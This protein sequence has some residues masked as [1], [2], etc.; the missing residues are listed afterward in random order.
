MASESTQERTVIF[1]YFTKSAFL[2]VEDSLEIGKLRLFLGKYKR[3]DGMQVGTYHF[4]DVDAARPLLMDLSWARVVKFIDYKGGSNG[5]GN[6]ISRVLS[7]KSQDDSVWFEVKNGPGKKSQ[8]GAVMPAGDATSDVSIPLKVD[9]ARRLA[10]ALL[11]YI[12]AHEVAQAVVAMLDGPASPAPASLATTTSSAVPFVPVISAGLEEPQ[13]AP[14]PPAQK[15]AHPGPVDGDPG[16]SPKFLLQEGIV[17]TEADGRI[18]MDLLGIVDGEPSD[19]GKK[20]IRLFFDWRKVPGYDGQE[21]DSRMQAAAKA[22][23][24]ELV[25][26][27]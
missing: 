22:I 24:G 17:K 13:P 12:S 6:I 23:L 27:K 10:L 21:R 20:R 9:D 18:L 3:G 7:V 26:E 25:P 11:A 4:L 16:M 14:V 1:S 8:T 5:S 2:N 19:I 15:P